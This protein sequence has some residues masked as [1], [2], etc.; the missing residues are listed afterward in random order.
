MLRTR[1][2]RQAGIT[3][4]LLPLC[5]TNSIIITTEI[6][7]IIFIVFSWYE[8]WSRVFLY[9]DKGLFP[10]NFSETSSLNLAHLTNSLHEH[11]TFTGQ[12][13]K[14][15][16]CKIRMNCRYC[17]AEINYSLRMGNIWVMDAG[18]E[19]LFGTVFLFQVVC[20]FK[21]L[22]SGSPGPAHLPNIF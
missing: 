2:K 5:N 15:N 19:F 12:K 3:L 14:L 1:K 8:L 16:G 4:I 17:L 21:I 6:C 20:F 13:M 10:T 7:V 22:Y 18:T 9:E 11:I